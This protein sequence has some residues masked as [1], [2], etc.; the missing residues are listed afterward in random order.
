MTP[1]PAMENEQVSANTIWAD[2][3]LILSETELQA[4]SVLLRGNM[5]IKTFADECGIMLEVLVDGINEKAM[6]H[7]GDN[8]LDDA[9]V[10]YDDYM[11]HVKELLR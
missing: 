6:D 8:L 1:I 10:L 9:F 7:I 3:R 4:L 5:D 11:E 2:F